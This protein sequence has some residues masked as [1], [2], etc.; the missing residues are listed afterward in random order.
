MATLSTKYEYLNTLTFYRKGF[1]QELIRVAMQEELIS[2]KEGVEIRDL[3]FRCIAEGCENWL[4]EHEYDCNINEYR[5]IYIKN[6]MTILTLYL[7][8]EMKPADALE[9]LMKTPAHKIHAEAIRYYERRMNNVYLKLKAVEAEV[10]KVKQMIEPYNDLM[11]AIIAAYGVDEGAKLLE[12]TT[13]YVEY[14]TMNFSNL[15]S[16][17]NIVNYFNDYVDAFITETRIMAKFG[18]KVMK[19]LRGKYDDALTNVLFEYVYCLLRTKHPK[20]SENKK[21]S[22]KRQLILKMPQEEVFDMMF[23]HEE[24]VKFSED[25]KNY[26]RRHF[27]HKLE[28]DGFMDYM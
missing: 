13:W 2:L 19:T 5:E 9:L 3:M 21:N 20:L 26:L 23:S 7:F 28:A 25:E 14:I 1:F 17:E 11:K 24:L 12:D 4:T 8:E 16:S 15:D 18:E 6:H 27:L 10:R 22:E